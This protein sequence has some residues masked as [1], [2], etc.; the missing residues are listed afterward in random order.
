MSQI[1][2]EK[3]HLL[4]RSKANRSLVD[5][6]LLWDKLSGEQSQGTYQ[7]TVEGNHRKQISKRLATIEVRYLCTSV[8][9]PA[10]AVGNTIRETKLYAVEAREINTTE[11]SP[12]LWRLI[13]TY[14]IE[15]YEDAC[16]IIQWYACRWLIEQVFRLLKNQGF[17]IESSELEEGW[18]LESYVY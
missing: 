9:R 18:Q 12:V 14:P 16:L 15:T 6:G 8:K 1:P 13:T 4:I 17:D 11:K 7:I 2:D 10:T 5:G 3:Y